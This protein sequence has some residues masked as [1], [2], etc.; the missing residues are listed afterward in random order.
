MKAS[1][2][3]PSIKISRAGLH[4]RK[5]SKRKRLLIYMR[6]GYRCYICLNRYDKDFLTVDHVR[7]IASGGDDDTKNLRAAC[8]MCNQ[9]KADSNP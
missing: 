2:D 9:I 4:H 3:F 7:P 5:V 1:R 6:D 8:R